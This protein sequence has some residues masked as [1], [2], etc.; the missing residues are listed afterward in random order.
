MIEQA[1]INR[2]MLPPVG[3]Y[4]RLY[5]DLLKG[6]VS[7]NQLGNRLIHLAEQARTFKQIDILSELAFILSNLPL[8]QYRIIGQ[9]YLALAICRNGSGDLEQATAIFE[10][11]ASEGPLIYRAEAMLSL[12]SIACVN[13][14]LDETIRYCMEAAKAGNF[15]TTIKALKGIA[16]LKGLEGSHHSAVDDLEKLYPMFRHASPYIYFDYLNSYAVELSEVGRMEEAK[17]ISTLVCSS[18][19]GTYDPEW[20]KT[21]SGIKQ[22]LYKPE[23]GETRYDVSLRIG[24]ASRSTIAFHKVFKES[25]NTLTQVAVDENENSELLEMNDQQEV[26]I[27][28]FLNGPFRASRS[29][30]ILVTMAREKQHFRKMRREIIDFLYDNAY[31]IPTSNLDNALA[32]LRRTTEDEP[33]K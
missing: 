33:S 3:K 27:L 13:Q 25:E 4:E 11:V 6:F 20:R 30:R 26:R 5:Q 23:K 1:T 17:N 24:R 2:F 15:N 18:P 22:N 7:Y 29:Q 21:L 8:K 28:D 31:E 12:S 16:I 19:F 14:Q 10:K 32:S 9:Y